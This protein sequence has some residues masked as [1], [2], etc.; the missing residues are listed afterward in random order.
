MFYLFQPLDKI[1]VTQGF[2]L[3]PAAYKKYGMKGHNGIDYRVR[4]VDSPLGKRYVSAAADGVVEVVRWDIKGY[5]VHVRIRHSDGSL[6]IYGHLTKPYVSKDEQVKA[7][8]I[9]GLSGNTGDS[10]AAHLH[11]E[12]R[13]AGWEKE[14]KNGY[15][16]AV[17]PT[18][19][20]LKTQVK[21]F[22][23]K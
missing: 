9:I 16:G 11:F 12:Y 8:Q 15:A 3:N 10:T 21:Q 23:K 1:Y 19:F 4:F 2:G 13:P 5:G 20:M 22:F 6:T 17:D 18:L 14:T 7:Q